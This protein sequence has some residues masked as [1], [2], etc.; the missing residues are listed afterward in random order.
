MSEHDA[1]AERIVNGWLND[2]PVVQ[3]GRVSE[4]T[5]EEW[6][7]L[8]QKIATALRE[9]RREALQDAK[10]AIVDSCKACD[11]QGFIVEDYTESEHGCN[12]D[13]REC[14][15]TCPVPVAA[16]RQIQCEYCGSPLQTIDHLITDQPEKK[17]G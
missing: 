6:Q 13:E 1:E 11:G 12:G 9:A 3:D 16:Q 4:V 7:R 8:H 15:N 17:D 5:G 2:Y 14:Q 10:I